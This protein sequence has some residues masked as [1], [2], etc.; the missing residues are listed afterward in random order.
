MPDHADAAASAADRPAAT[1]PTI[2]ARLRA[3]GCVFAEEEAR[4]LLATA[5]NPRELAAMIDKRVAGSPL[6]YV[7]GWAEFCGLRIFVG[8]GVFVPRRR[9]EFLV[10]QAVAAVKSRAGAAAAPIVLDLCCGSGAI[11]LAV[12]TVLAEAWGTEEAGRGGVELH[13]ADIDP[14]ATAYA[15]RNLAAAGGQVYV[16]DLYDPLPAQLRG[17]IDVI[18]VN[19][20]YVPSDEVGLMPAEARLHEP[21]VALDGGADGVGIHRRVAAEAPA[22]LA[23]DGSLLFETSERQAPLTEAAMTA[24]GLT[25]SVVSDDDLDTTV[26][27]GRA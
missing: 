13:A 4:L 1:V 25:T 19:A 11:G 14:G 10:D 16:G 27:I 6:E 3:A 26:V 9:S 5:T 17:R 18:V 22:W 15:R 20:P 2:V 7:V 24:A 12:A 21:L 8:P 23:S